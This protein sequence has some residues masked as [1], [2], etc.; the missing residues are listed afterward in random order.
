MTVSAPTRLAV[1]SIFFGLPYA[2]TLGAGFL[3]A[4]VGVVAV[5]WLARRHEGVPTDSVVLAGLNMS[6]LFGAATGVLQYAAKS[7]C[8]TARTCTIS[9]NG[10]P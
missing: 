6:L 5:L 1:A 3:C 2:A 9:R 8:A 4:A 7:G 10:R